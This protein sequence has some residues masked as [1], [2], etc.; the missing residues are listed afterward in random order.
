MHLVLQYL[1]ERR[2]I[3]SLNLVTFDD[4]YCIKPIVLKAFGELYSKT[5]IYQNPEHSH[6]ANRNEL[7]NSLKR[8]KR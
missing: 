2:Q 7:L 4:F 5:T 8:W 6:A 3:D 1:L